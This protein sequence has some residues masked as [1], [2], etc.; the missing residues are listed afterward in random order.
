MKQATESVRESTI[1]P[2]ARNS[3]DLRDQLT[4]KACHLSSLLTLLYGDGGE[5]FRR[6]NNDIQDNVL[7]LAATLSRDLESLVERVK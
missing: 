7:W 5:A 4:E 2:M 6:Y 1:T 3:A